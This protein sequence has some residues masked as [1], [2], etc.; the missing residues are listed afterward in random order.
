MWGSW[1]PYTN[2]GIVRLFAFSMWIK[3]PC[4][5]VQHWGLEAG[6]LRWSCS[7][8]CTLQEAVITWSNLVIWKWL[9]GHSTPTRGWPIKPGLPNFR[10]RAGANQDEW[11]GGRFE[12]HRIEAQCVA[13][14]PQETGRLTK[15]QASGPSAK[16][17]TRQSRVRLRSGILWVFLL[18]STLRFWDSRCTPTRTEYSKISA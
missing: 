1:A 3:L 11:P 18:L 12:L 14:L 5:H 10:C 16:W 8:C 2:L 6:D 17:G 15:E 7:G 9:G 4:K 13:G